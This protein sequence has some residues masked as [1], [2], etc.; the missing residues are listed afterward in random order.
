M[1]IIFEFV[2]WTL[3]S[4]IILHEKSYPSVMMFVFTL[5]WILLSWWWTWCFRYE[6]TH[7][8]HIFGNYS[9]VCVCGFNN[10]NDCDTGMGT[11]LCALFT[12]S[13]VVGFSSYCRNIITFWLNDLIFWNIGIVTAAYINRLVDMFFTLVRTVNVIRDCSIV[14]ALSRLSGEVWKSYF[15]NVYVILILH[16]D[17]LSINWCSNCF[18]FWFQVHI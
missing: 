8:L 16:V 2:L 15:V 17:S 3:S 9:E 14:F 4:D 12:S 1:Y 13:L 5:A 10:R 11:Y 7:F 6:E 18:I